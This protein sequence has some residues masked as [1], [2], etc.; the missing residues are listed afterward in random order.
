MQDMP[1]P[2][3]ITTQELRI[4]DAQGHPRLILSA[5]GGLPSIILLRQNGTRGATVTL[6]QADRPSLL[7][8]NPDPSGPTAV[9]EIDDKG[10]H[11]KLDRPGGASSYLFL[12]NM[13]GS[14]IVLSDEDSKRRASAVLAPDGSLVLEG[15][16]D[17]ANESSKP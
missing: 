6:D 10:T 12:N 1:P 13:G 8:A 5:E 17:P 9:L 11:L 3:A 4:V 14:G 7:L 15:I 2:A 16:G